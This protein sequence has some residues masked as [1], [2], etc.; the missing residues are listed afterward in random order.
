MGMNVTLVGPIPTPGV[1]FLTRTLRLD[2][3]IV[4]LVSQ[5]TSVG[6]RWKACVTPNDG[7]EDGTSLCSNEVTIVADGSDIFVDNEDPQ[8]LIYKGKN[9]KD[10][11]FKEDYMELVTGGSLYRTRE[12]NPCRFK[13][14]DI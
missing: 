1:S 4:T 6:D 2:A 8:F 10:Y 5:E 13:D 9:P 7:T 12:E 3:G 11:K 14:W